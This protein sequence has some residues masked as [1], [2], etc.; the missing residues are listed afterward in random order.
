MRL[1]ACQGIQVDFGRRAGG[2]DLADWRVLSRVIM[3]TLLVCGITRRI[4]STIEVVPVL[5]KR[6][7]KSRAEPFRQKAV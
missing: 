5:W 1:G 6:V 7:Q 3:L 4:S 2:A